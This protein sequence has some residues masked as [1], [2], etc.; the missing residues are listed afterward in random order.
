MHKLAKLGVSWRRKGWSGVV[1]L[2]YWI[3]LP[4][5]VDMI[6]GGHSGRAFEHN[7]LRCRALLSMVG[8]RAR[9][10]YGPIRPRPDIPV[11]SNWGLLSIATKIETWRT[12]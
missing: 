4:V 7:E 10:K 8:R 2:R 12:R 9:P 6:V 5:D 3:A 1:G 11:P